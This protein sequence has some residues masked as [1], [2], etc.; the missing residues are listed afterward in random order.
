[1]IVEKF[2]FYTL[3]EKK[4][5]PS[6]PVLVKL[7]DTYSSQGLPYYVCYY[8]DEV[9]TYAGERIPGCFVEAGGE[10]YWDIDPAHVVAWASIGMETL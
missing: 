8:I 5:Q 3:D 1:M 4:P 6:V 9:T 10:E 7:D 2:H